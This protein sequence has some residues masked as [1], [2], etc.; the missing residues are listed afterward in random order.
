MVVLVPAW[1]YRT[2]QLLLGT[3]HTALVPQV[4]TAQ[5]SEHLYTHGAE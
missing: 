5:G 3:A 4:L 2:L 1:P